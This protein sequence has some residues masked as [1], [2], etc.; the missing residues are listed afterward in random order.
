MQLHAN[1]V[2]TRLLPSGV[3]ITPLLH[4][5]VLCRPHALLH[6]LRGGANG[7]INFRQGHAPRQLARPTDEHLTWGWLSW[8]PSRV[9]TESA[10]TKGRGPSI[11]KCTVVPQIGKNLTWRDLPS[12]PWASLRTRRC[13]STRYFSSL[14]VWPSSN[15]R[16]ST[17]SR[18]LDVSLISLAEPVRL[19]R[20]S[21]SPRA[22]PAFVQSSLEANELH[23]GT[24]TPWGS[25]RGFS[26]HDKDPLPQK[27]HLLHLSIARA[28]PSGPRREEQDSGGGEQREEKM[29]IKCPK[30]AAEQFERLGGKMREG[31]GNVQDH[32]WGV[33]DVYTWLSPVTP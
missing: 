26:G 2:E 14:R 21:A 8:S 12:P 7:E 9:P 4:Y 22:C 28:R 24:R 25:E 1:R 3:Q 19:A 29:T 30:E 23:R 27:I 6:K 15:T 11:N 33:W 16:S 17:C 13:F 5:Q 20:I 18:T 32:E 31:W 10:S